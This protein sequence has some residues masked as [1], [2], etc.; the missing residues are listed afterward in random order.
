MVGSHGRERMLS[1]R[2]RQ[3]GATG[4]VVTGSASSTPRTPPEEVPTWRVIARKAL[5]VLLSGTVIYILAPVLAKVFAAWPR[6]Y[7]LV[8]VWATLGFVAEA[9]SFICSFL[10][11]R[12]ALRTRA[13]FAVVTSGLVGNAVTNV[14]P[15][16]D[17]TG[18]AVE[19]HMLSVAGVESGAAVGGLTA[20]ALIQTGSLL[21]LP[22]AA[23]PA[24]L[25]G[26][27]VSRGLT[28]LAYLGIG[29]FALYVVAGSAIFT[30]DWPLR[31]AGRVAQDVR[32]RLRRRRQPLTGLSERLIHERNSTRD[33]LGAKW[34]WALLDA[35]GK[36]GFDFICLLA[37]LAAARANPEPWIVL[38]AYAATTVIALLPVTPGGLGLVE[39]SLTGLLV[40][41]GI[42]AA[43][44]FVATLAYRVSSYWLPTFVGPVAYLAFR[45]RYE[46]GGRDG[47]VDEDS[48]TPQHDGPTPRGSRLCP[49]SVEPSPTPQ[50]GD[51]PNRASPAG[52]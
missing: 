24:I 40:L 25:A 34:P 23:L 17:A 6:L 21:A 1:S 47:S 22:I 18:A 48:A 11:K 19:F 28:H 52:S 31:L 10:L 15:G 5:P 13:L 3:R 29:L 4:D 27:P 45:R 14:L 33:A 46:R 9:G 12:I 38:I 2:S 16:S 35:I 37:M 7:S 51:D 39:G 26:V 44:A 43:N 36:V 41:A 42:P 49:G 32:N 30:A 8:P 50:G 20:T